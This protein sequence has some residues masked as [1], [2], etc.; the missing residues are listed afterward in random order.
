MNTLLSTLAV[1]VLAA[2]CMVNARADETSG[3][4]KAEPKSP[5]DFKVKD[6][7]GKEVNLAKYRGKVVMIVNVA[8]KCGLTP[9]YDQ[10]ADLDKKYRAKGLAILGFPANNF[11]G[12]EPGTNEEIKTFCRLKYDAEF[13]MFSKISVAGEDQAPLYKWLTSEETNKAFAGDIEW[14]FAKFLVNREGKVIARFHPKVKPDAP[15]VIEA[16]EKALSER[17]EGA[18][19]EA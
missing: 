2:S 10:L 13:D 16:I 8:S 7:D 4:K 11:N 3:D 6:I 15:E 5:L 12:Q 17:P 18:K 14:N 19:E 9:Q 1:C